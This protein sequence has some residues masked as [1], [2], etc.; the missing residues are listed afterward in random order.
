MFRY[1]LSWHWWIHA[2][3]NFVIVE[4][5]QMFLHEVLSVD[6]LQHT[7]ASWCL[8]RKLL[9]DGRKAKSIK[10]LYFVVNNWYLKK[11]VSYGRHPQTRV[12]STEQNKH[13]VIANMQIMIVSWISKPR[14]DLWFFYK[15]QL[16]VTVN[17]NLKCI[18]LI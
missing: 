12:F 8:E 5:R 11:K 9:L 3:H 4:V 13:K 17:M 10:L 16:M 18:T 14:F 1:C 15:V 2:S 6:R 7:V